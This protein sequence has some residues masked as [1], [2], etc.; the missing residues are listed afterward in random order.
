MR[1][2]ARSFIGAILLILYIALYAL[3][4]MAFSASRINGSSWEG[5]FYV[6]AGFAWLP[7]AMWIISYMAKGKKQ[8]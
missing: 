7:G 5:V 8:S 3:L 6:F 4:V 1:P 2:P